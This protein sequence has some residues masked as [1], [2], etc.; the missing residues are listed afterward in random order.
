M[1]R[2]QNFVA[3][4]HLTSGIDDSV[5]SIPV[6][7]TGGFPDA[8]FVL[9]IGNDGIGGGELVLCTAIED[10]TTF[11]VE[12]GFDGTSAQA[13]DENTL[14]EHTSAAIDYREGGIPRLTIA[15]RD[16]LADEELWE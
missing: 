14:V 7:S 2:Y 11:A 8:P 12:R 5:T 4:T 15:E 16:A 6:A 10:A 13:H 1:R 3:P 9:A